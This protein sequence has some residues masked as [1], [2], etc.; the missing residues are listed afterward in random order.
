MQSLLRF[1]EIMTDIIVEVHGIT[2]SQNL[3][4]PNGLKVAALA[5]VSTVSKENPH[6]GLAKRIVAVGD[7]DIGND[8]LGL[9]LTEDMTSVEKLDL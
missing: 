7:H 3:Q 1:G 4:H 5:L 8:L 2:I 6:F 9:E